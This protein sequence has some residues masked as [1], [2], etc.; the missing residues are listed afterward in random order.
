MLLLI[1][2]SKKLIFI[3]KIID[4]QILF[5]HKKKNVTIIFTMQFFYKAVA[6]FI[7][8][9]CICFWLPMIFC[10]QARERAVPTEYE[11]RK[12]GGCHLGLST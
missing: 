6:A 8:S 12:S 11:W 10:L 4:S 5:I 9:L 7:F 2:K 1:L 3:Y